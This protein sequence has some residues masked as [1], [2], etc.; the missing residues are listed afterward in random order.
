MA[1]QTKKN[2][3]EAFRCVEDDPGSEFMIKGSS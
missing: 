1:L 3:A 2:K